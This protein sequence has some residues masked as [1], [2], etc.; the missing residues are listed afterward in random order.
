M[1]ILTLDYR[2]Y[3]SGE[4]WLTRV[5]SKC[6]PNAKIIKTAVPVGD[7]PPVDYAI[8]LVNPTALTL[9]DPVGVYT[10]FKRLKT[11][12]ILVTEGP[13]SSEGK[14]LISAF[15]TPLAL[16]DYVKHK[17]GVEHVIRPKIDVPENVPPK[18]SR[19]FDIISVI[20]NVGTVWRYRKG[21][22]IV[23]KVIESI[24]ASIAT[25]NYGDVKKPKG[26]FF[27]FAL[28]DYHLDRMYKHSKV[29]LWPSRSEG[30]GLPVIEAM[31]VGTV[32]VCS[33]APAHNEFCEGVKISTT[34]LG[35]FA[36]DPKYP[37]YKA[38]WYDSCWEDY[39]KGIYYALEHWEELSERARKKVVDEYSPLSS[40]CEELKSW[41]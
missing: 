36:L 22:D 38:D 39:V 24:D 2:K 11:I 29:L 33:D 19:V 14:M 30:F 7:P 15:S 3:T 21:I 17:T 32:P 31:A 23:E 16:S 41:M 12:A 6:F 26:T 34:Y 8:V 40:F 10:F 5:L 28:S 9:G 1:R 20:S 4:V 27:S 18:S 37:K 13:V 35:S 25:S